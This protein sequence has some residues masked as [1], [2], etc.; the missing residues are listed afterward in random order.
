MESR[1]IELLEEIAEKLSDI[2]VQ[3]A[4]LSRK[5]DNLP[6]SD[7]TYETYSELQDV[8]SDLVKLIKK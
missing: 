8:H 4:D 1:Q 7:Y 6:T 2:S 5:V 3:L